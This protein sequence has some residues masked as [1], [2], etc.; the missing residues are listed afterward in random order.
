MIDL[1]KSVKKHI[2]TV[3][4]VMIMSLLSLTGYVMSVITLAMDED[5]DVL[6]YVNQNVFAGVAIHNIKEKIVGPEGLINDVDDFLLYQVAKDTRF[7]ADEH[8][9][10][11]DEDYSK[12]YKEHKSIVINE[13][14]KKKDTKPSKKK[15]NDNSKKKPNKKTEQRTSEKK[16][17]KKEK[18]DLDKRDENVEED[19]SEVV[20]CEADNNYF[21]DALF[22]GDSRVVGLGAF[23]NLPNITVYAVKAFQIY[24]LESKALINT[25]LGAITVPQALLMQENKYKKVYM[26]FGLNEMGMDEAKFDEYYYHLIDLVKYTQPDAIVYVQGVMHVST[27]KD[28]DPSV[29]TNARIDAR[30]EHLRQMAEAEDVIFLDL[31]EVFTDE[32]NALPDAY[33]SDGVHLKAQYINIW[34]DYL[35]AHAYARKGWEKKHYEREYTGDDFPYIMNYFMPDAPAPENDENVQTGITEDGE[36]FTVEGGTLEKVE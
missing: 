31:N 8:G 9:E 18:K 23:S 14:S 28:A 16:T 21:M 24:T 29:I 15:K 19:P 6:S 34:V 30:N 3:A 36:V 12:I 32:N 1:L 27:A 35:K 2:L 7:Y 10:K 26:K 11:I 20:S 4:I 13:D 5:P 22:I 25:E 33:A 17:E